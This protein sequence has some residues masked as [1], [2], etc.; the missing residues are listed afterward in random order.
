MLPQPHPNLQHWNKIQ[1]ENSRIG[2]CCYQQTLPIYDR[3]N[4]TAAI[5]SMYRRTPYMHTSKPLTTVA[6]PSSP[7]PNASYNIRQLHPYMHHRHGLFQRKYNFWLTAQWVFASVS[8][9]RQGQA[10]ERNWTVILS[11]EGWYTNHCT[12]HA[13]LGFTHFFRTSGR[14]SSHQMLVLDLTEKP[15]A[16]YS[17]WVGNSP[18]SLRRAF[19]L[20]LGYKSKMSGKPH[21][22]KPGRI[23]IIQ[24]SSFHPASTLDTNSTRNNRYFIL[25]NLVIK[26]EM[27]GGFDGDEGI[28]TPATL[29][30]P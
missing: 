14:F 15:E 10:C 8:V 4:G 3:I 2:H 30:T 21:W 28:R 6:S 5:P 22:C 16:I 24:V 17:T 18:S 19:R 1:R 26:P 29:L 25:V 13:H 20:L 23:S 7:K 12:T 11:L 9:P 27:P